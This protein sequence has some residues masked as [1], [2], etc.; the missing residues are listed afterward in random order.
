[1]TTSLEDLMKFCAS[2]MFTCL[3]RN[4][5]RWKFREYQRLGDVKKWVKIKMREDCIRNDLIKCLLMFFTLWS[6]G[7]A[8]RPVPL[9]VEV[10]WVKNTQQITTAKRTNDLDTVKIS[11]GIVNP[12]DLC[13]LGA[14]DAPV[15]KGLVTSSCMRDLWHTSFLKG[16]TNVQEYICRHGNQ[17]PDFLDFSICFAKFQCWL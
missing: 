4:D 15:Y 10:S 12:V 11:I 2:C 17:N 8:V 1:M 16:L 9:R 7:R 6:K 13:E 14:D 5:R 3:G